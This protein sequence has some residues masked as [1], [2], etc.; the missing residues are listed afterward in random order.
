MHKDTIAVKNEWRAAKAAGRFSGSYK[1]YLAANEDGDK[2]I[3]GIRQ[4]KVDADTHIAS[5]RL[6]KSK[7]ARRSGGAKKQKAA[8]K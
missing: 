2:R 7:A 3:R 4:R 8:A 5:P 6:W 1:A